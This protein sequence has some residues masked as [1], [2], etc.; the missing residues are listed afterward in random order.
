MSGS[1]APKRPAQV[2]DRSLTTATLERPGTGVLSATSD[3][4]TASASL[5]TA[6]PE[7]QPSSMHSL[8]FTFTLLFIFLRFS[9]VHEFISSNI[10]VDTHLIIIT[11]APAY[12]FTLLSGRIFVGLRDACTRLWLCFAAWMTFAGIGSYWHAGSLPWVLGFLE[13]TAP[14]ILIIPALAV[15]RKHVHLLVSSVGLGCITTILLGFIDKDYFG[16]R[17]YVAAKGSDIQDPNDFAAHVILMLPA[18]AYFT[19][20]RGR[21]PFVKAIGLAVMAIGFI[22]ILSTGSRGG[23]VGL[24]ASL[25][26]VLIVAKPRVRFGLLAGLPVAAAL[27]LPF[28]PGS[29]VSRLKTVFSEDDP[30]SES[31]VSREARR[32]LLQESWNI[33]LQHPVFGVGPGV[34]MEFQADDVKG[35]GIKGMWHVTHNAYTQISSECGIPAALFYIGALAAT[36]LTL[37]KSAKVGDPVFTPICHTLMVMLAGFC[38]CLFFLSIGYNVQIIALGGIAVCIRSILRSEGKLDAVKTP[39][40]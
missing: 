6:S 8:G 11:G 13:N 38:V 12:L 25:L 4:F 19:L 37:W 21:S 34:F 28:V 30:N 22:E 7:T 23:V 20:R 14:V 18:L 9:Y 32:E 1:G 15:T 10:D 35:S 40:F 31:A 39:A 29:S 27:L 17:E 5:P 2:S 16:G 36:F 26:C 33:T 3:I 24:A